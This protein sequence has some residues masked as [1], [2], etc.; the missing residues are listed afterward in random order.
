MC[1]HFD[2]K[3]LAICTCHINHGK[4]VW[5]R[6]GNTRSTHFRQVF[7]V[8]FLVAKKKVEK[9]LFIPEDVV[10]FLMFVGWFVELLECVEL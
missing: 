1:L 10:Q 3:K 7:N 2:V 5:S 8:F 4:P 9:T 6:T